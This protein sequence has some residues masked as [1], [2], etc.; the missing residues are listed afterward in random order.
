MLSPGLSRL[1][2]AVPAVAGPSEPAG[3]GFDRVLGLANALETCSHQP[4]FARVACEY[5][6]RGRYCEEP[7][8]S[9]IPQCADRP[10]RDYGQ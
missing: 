8:A 2:D 6:A 7:G 10:P 1:C 3:E 4:I 5:R 9:Q